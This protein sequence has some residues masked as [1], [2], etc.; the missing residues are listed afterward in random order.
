MID[1]KTVTIIQKYIDKR[2]SKA[3]KFSVGFFVCIQF[4]YNVDLYNQ[5]SSSTSICR[6]RA[7]FP[8]VELLVL[9]L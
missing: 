1:G 8:S 9:I 6:L 3:E 5:I 2:K 4:Y 7:S